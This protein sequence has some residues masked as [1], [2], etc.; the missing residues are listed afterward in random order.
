MSKANNKLSDTKVKTLKTK[1][2]HFDG[3]GLYLELTAIGSKLWRLKY[4]FAGTEKL[5]ALGTYPSVKLATARELKDLA[6]SQ[7]AAG[8]DPSNEKRVQKAKLALDAAQ[9]V[10]ACAEAWIDHMS[11]KWGQGTKLAVISSFERDVYPLIGSRSISTI[12]AKDIIKAAKTVEARGATDQAARLLQ[13]LKSFTRWATVNQ[14]VE[15]NPSGDIKPDDVLKKRVVI[16][17]PSLHKDQLRDFMVRLQDYQG[18]AVVAAGIRFLA[19]TALR[20]GEVRH[21]EWSDIDFKTKTLAIPA[22]RMKMGREHRVPLST[23]ALSVLEQIKPLNGHRTLVFSSIR[24]PGFPMSENTLNLGLQRM[25]FQATSHGM[26][27]TFSTI[28]NESLNFKPEVIEAALA[29]VRGD[30]VAAAYNRTDYFN[31]RTKLMQ[32]WAN[33]LDSSARHSSQ[34]IAAN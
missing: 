25:G 14:I 12:L 4:R 8:I 24:K 9:T 11:P 20:P 28:A 31:E 5:L 21:L 6:K 34:E 30:K 29:H 17:R 18:D 7:I 27:S 1:G 15:T 32:W 3:D 23:Q 16:N 10:K 2:K 13:R 19:L 26:R 22:S 33:F